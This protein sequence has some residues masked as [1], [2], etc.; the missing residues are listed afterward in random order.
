[1]RENKIK[2]KWLM[3]NY[4][5]KITV[6]IPYPKDFEFRQEASGLA[7]AVSRAIRRF[8]KELNGKKKIK[9]VFI[10]AIQL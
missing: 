7:T 1:M 8:R 3:K 4:L 10:R 6:Q 9:E 2:S 5:V